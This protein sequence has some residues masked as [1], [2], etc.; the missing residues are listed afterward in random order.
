MKSLKSIKTQEDKN[1]FVRIISGKV[2]EEGIYEY[3]LITNRKIGKIGEEFE[4]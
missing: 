1:K 4:I 3:T 2:I